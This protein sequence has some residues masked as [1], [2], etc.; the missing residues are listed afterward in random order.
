MNI[1]H[2]GLI[3]ISV[4]LTAIAQPLLKVGMSSATVQHSYNQGDQLAL[5]WAMA[6]NP[7]VAFGLLLYAFSAVVWLLALA[8]ADISFAYP[9]VGLGFVLTLII[10]WLFLDETMSV[11][12]L[13]GT[14]L[15][16]G[17][18]MLVSRS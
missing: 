6:T 10:G 17:G 8:K 9:F 4:M 5:A 15:V 18:V 14:L 3:L 1:K 2:I 11:P 16:V 12:R 7:Y 13:T